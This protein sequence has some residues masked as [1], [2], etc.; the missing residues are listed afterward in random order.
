[1]WKLMA[2]IYNCHHKEAQ[3]PRDFWTFRSSEHGRKMP[4]LADM[5]EK[6]QNL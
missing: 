3:Q 4:T 2:V 1:M 5:K 6:F